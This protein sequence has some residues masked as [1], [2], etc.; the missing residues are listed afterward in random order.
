M[1]NKY[2]REGLKER[3]EIPRGQDLLMLVLLREALRFKTSLGSRRG[4]EIK[5]L[6]IFLSLG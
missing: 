4:Y 1:L 2:R 5:F 6:P 3:V